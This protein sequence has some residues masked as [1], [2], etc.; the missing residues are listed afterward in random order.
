MLSEQSLSLTDS[1]FSESVDKSL[2]LNPVSGMDFI[3]T[4]R[5]SNFTRKILLAAGITALFLF[6]LKKSP[7]AGSTKV[8][9]LL[10]CYPFVVG[11]LPLCCTL[12]N[13]FCAAFQFSQHE[14][15]VTHVLVTGGAGYIGSH[16][17]LR[18]LRD[19]Y[20]VTIVVSPCHT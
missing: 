3:E 4:K 19:S 13:S 17:V 12:F 8:L 2:K 1:R 14:P 10:D 16:A 20:R 7:G 11:L 18:L 15:G 9:L 6:M 5:R